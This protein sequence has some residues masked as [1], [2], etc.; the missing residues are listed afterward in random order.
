MV[1]DASS[2]ESGVLL[3]LS[4]HVHIL[5][6]EINGI[7]VGLEAAQER[8]AEAVAGV[9][10]SGL[11]VGGL[12]ILSRGLHRSLLHGSLLLLNGSLVSVV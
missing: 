4:Q 12:S 11:L 2:T 9:L 6:T 1:S 10:L 7:R 8:L 3:A 5:L